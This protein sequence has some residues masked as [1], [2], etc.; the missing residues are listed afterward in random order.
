MIARAK[1]ALQKYFGFQ[2]FRGGQEKVIQ[3]LLNGQDT[4][5]IMPTGAGKSITYQIPALLLEGVTLV[6]SP[7]ISLMKDQV[8]SLQETGVSGTFINSSLSSREVWS[9]IQKIEYGEYK[10]VYLAPERLESEEV[11]S[12]LQN[13]PISF[14]AVDEA[15]C[16]S[17]WGHDFRPSYLR[18]NRFVQSLPMRPL[19]GAFTATATEEVKRDIIFRL[20]LKKP[21]VFIGG[22]DR[23]NLKFIVLRGENKKEFILNYLKNHPHQAGIIYAAT[24]KEVD[25]LFKFLKGKGFKVGRYHAGMRDS[26]RKENQETFIFDDISIIIATNAFGMGIDKSNVRFVIHHN[27]PKNMESYYQEAGRAGRDGEASECILLFGQQDV[28]IQKLLIEETITS[29]E[30]QANEYQKLQEMVAYCH[31]STCLRKTILEYFGEVQVPE[32]CFNCSNCEEDKEKVDVTIDAQK[33]LSCVYRMKERFGMA[34]VADVL[35]GSLN[36]RVRQFKL[37]QLSTHGIM[38][39]TPLQEIKDRINFLAAEGYLSVN[40]GQY[41]IL[42]LSP[43]AVPVLKGQEKV[44]QMLLPPKKIPGT[45]MEKIFERLRILRKKIAQQE[46]L[47]PYMIFPDNTLRE[48]ATLCPGDKQA[49]LNVNGVGEKKLEKYGELFIKEIKEALSSLKLNLNRDLQQVTI[50]QVSDIKKELK[51]KPNK[52]VNKEKKASHLIT[53]ELYREGKTLPAIADM[54]HLTVPTIENHLLRCAEEGYETLLDDFI[55]AEQE[56]LILDAIQAVGCEKLKPLKEI[57][58]EEISYLT[59]KAVLLKLKGKKLISIK[60]K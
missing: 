19:I 36:K 25:N 13:L 60:S 27:M 26:E 24:R 10:L 1:D 8:D 54:R 57:L 30:R 22:F 7:L 47:P 48:M 11:L 49:L 43:K 35:K 23:P 28:L 58:P 12:K 4:L 16:V 41:P 59:I 50:G 3:S 18:I 53:L 6:I 56:P 34:M 52:E 5:T 9:R 15:H 44:Y 37:N 33:I 38:R 21:Y 2:D 20:G 51:V 42:K 39:E 14:I 31:A 40:A 29:Q 46:G 45:D 55:P 32:Q 17:Q